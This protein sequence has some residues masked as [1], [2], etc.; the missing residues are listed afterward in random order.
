M[1]KNLIQKASV[2]RLL[3]SSLPRTAPH[4]YSPRCQPRSVSIAIPQIMDHSSAQ[5]ILDQQNI[6]FSSLSEL[7]ETASDLIS[8]PSRAALI[9][10]IQIR[11]DGSNEELE[12]EKPS[13]VDIGVDSSQAS[14]DVAT[15]LDH[16]RQEGSLESFSWTGYNMLRARGKRPPAFWE[17]LWKT[18][19]TLKNLDLWFYEHEPV[20]SPGYAPG[21]VSL[22]LLQKL[23]LDV[24]RGHGDDGSI[25]DQ[26]LRSSP[27]LENASLEFPNC[28]LEGCR[29]G[30][31]TWDYHFPKLHT[32]H[33]NAYDSNPAQL[34]S[35]FARN[36]SIKNLKFDMWSDEK[37]AD[38]ADGVLQ[39][40]EA[41]SID[42]AGHPRPFSDFL[43]ASAA[44]PIV[45]LCISNSPHS[46]YPLIRNVSGTLRCLE[47][48]TDI[49]FWRR[50]PEPSPSAGLDD[51]TKTLEETAL[52][53]EK[54]D[55][56]REE[57]DED[58]EEVSEGSSIPK[59][60]LAESRG[61]ENEKSVDK[62][63]SPPPQA[64]Q[65]LLSQLP[66]LKE[67]ALDLET[68]LTYMSDD[69]GG[70]GH[71][72]AMN[73]KDLISVLGHLPANSQL[74]AIRL[75]DSRGLPLPEEL[76]ESFPEIPSSIEYLRWDTEESKLLYRLER[77]E[78]KTKAVRCDPVRA[79]SVT[80]E[81]WT[82]NRILDY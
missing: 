12:E 59:E 63:I 41:L 75:S 23:H 36:P 82:E 17:A 71:P 54:P 76:L 7:S 37:R 32:L 34:F 64:I 14:I 79:S 44:R 11:D 56:E 68:G 25:I 60:P 28:D 27:N 40:L 57:L 50:E 53:S 26:I 48:K 22:E 73:E 55:L 62:P 72:A 8:N 74:R 81:L 51:V 78:G 38:L 29:L 42:V 30:G 2:P 49:D 46:C 67:F 21:P 13:V 35:F 24:S 58:N 31:L 3:L 15:I 45:H 20:L 16:V 77:S 69:E 19:A 9:K 1:V 70:W 61:D 80:G 47:I 43:S 52:S 33:L 18:A 4:F 5:T 10:A 65:N 6:E 39:N 66:E